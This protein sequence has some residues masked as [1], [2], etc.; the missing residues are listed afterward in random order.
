[1]EVMIVP[2]EIDE[3][4]Y[5]GCLLAPPGVPNETERRMMER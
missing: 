4:S 5:E 3:E 1:M 2:A